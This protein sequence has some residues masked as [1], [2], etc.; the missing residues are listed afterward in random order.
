MVGEAP[1]EKVSS[2]TFYIV[3]SRKQFAYDTIDVFYVGINATAPFLK[4]SPSRISF[5]AVWNKVDRLLL[6]KVIR[7]WDPTCR[8]S[9]CSQTSREDPTFG[10]WSR[11]SVSRLGALRRRRRRRSKIQF[12]AICQKLKG[13]RY[14]R[15]SFWRSWKSGLWKLKRP[16]VPFS[17]FC[18]DPKEHVF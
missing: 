4:R 17:G 18:A 16:R 11:A 9:W 7:N 8:K 5:A 12:P 14:A 10:S 1:R 6:L 13:E 2:K 3:W 15:E